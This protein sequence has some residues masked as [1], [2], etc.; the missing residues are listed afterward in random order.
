MKR[1]D[2]IEKTKS[3]FNNLDSF[4]HWLVVN[5]D[6]SYKHSNIILDAGVHYYK[7]IGQRIGEFNC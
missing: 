7:C 6:M 1:K 4:D 3:T 2:K 5:M